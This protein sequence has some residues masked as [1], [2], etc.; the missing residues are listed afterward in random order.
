MKK[1]ILSIILSIIVIQGYSQNREKKL[2]YRADSL[3]KINNKQTLSS[4]LYNGNTDGLIYVGLITS[5]EI[6]SFFLGGEI[7]LYDSYY[8]PL[9]SGSI[10]AN[11]KHSIDPQKKVNFNAISIGGHFTFI[12]LEGTVY[13]NN[14][15][16]FAYIIPK[17][18]F[19]YGTWSIFYGYGIPITTKYSQELSGHNLSL[20]YNLYLSAFKNHKSRRKS[21]GY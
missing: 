16:T 11:Y 3:R 5:C 14:E 18:G 9:Y 15:K 21:M 6:S 13:F 19:D 10:Y 1:I 4:L 2:N 7:K 12:G 8:L 20:K 17:V